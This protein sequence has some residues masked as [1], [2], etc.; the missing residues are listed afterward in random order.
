[1][2][3]MP[4]RKNMSNLFHDFTVEKCNLMHMAIKDHKDGVLFC[5]ADICWLGPLPEIPKET[6]IALSRHEIRLED[7]AK[8]GTYNAGFIY[9][10][11]L[12]SV[13]QWKE[14]SFKSSFFEQMSLN[15]FKDSYKFG[16]HINYG[17]WRMFQAPISAEEKK[18]EWSIHRNESHSGLCVKG[19]PVICIHTH[20]K[21][22]DLVTGT[23]NN[24][25]LDRLQILKK[26]RKIQAFLKFI[27]K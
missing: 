10:K 20:W 22:N 23:F 3:N 18:K 24:W 26:N 2:E 11:D 21:T 27:E 25:I 17:W 6:K 8:Y 1:M 13:L 7:E 16:S 19:E 9:M 5:D 12:D 15:I 4:S 14:A